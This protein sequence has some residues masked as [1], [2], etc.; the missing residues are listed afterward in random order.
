[1]LWFARQR[2]IQWLAVTVAISGLLL[3]VAV[4]QFP[5]PFLAVG[6]TPDSYLVYETT[7]RAMGTTGADE[8]LSRWVEASPQVVALR[9]GQDRVALVDPPDGVMAEV[10][11][12]RTRSLTLAVQSQT[13]AILTLAQFYFPGWFAWVDDAPVPVWPASQSGLIQVNVPAGAHTVQLEYRGAM[14]QR[15]AGWLSLCGLLA[16]IILLWFTRLL[17]VESSIALRGDRVD[18]VGDAM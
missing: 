5:R 13:S 16:T 6:A 18:H 17:V 7:F 2:S 8:F 12:T 10:R 4:Y 14:V 15:L 11:D 1:M 3:S 9:P